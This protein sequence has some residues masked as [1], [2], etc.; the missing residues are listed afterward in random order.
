VADET[1]RWQGW[2]AL[3]FALPPLLVCF[4]AYRYVQRLQAAQAVVA[5]PTLDAEHAVVQITTPPETPVGE[6]ERQV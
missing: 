5:T 4:M 1:I 3:S 6:E 2:L